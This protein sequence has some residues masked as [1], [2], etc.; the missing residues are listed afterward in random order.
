MFAKLTKKDYIDYFRSRG[1]PAT[2]RNVFV[3]D[4]VNCPY[5]VFT[6]PS[7]EGF[8]YAYYDDVVAFRSS[9]AI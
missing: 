1:F 6:F 4:K 3:I 8:E 7:R 5:A 2:Y 9:C